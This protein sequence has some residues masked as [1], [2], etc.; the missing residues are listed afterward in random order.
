M[1]PWHESRTSLKGESG[2]FRIDGPLSW[3][4]VLETVAEGSTFSLE[5]TAPRFTLAGGRVHRFPCDVQRVTLYGDGSDQE[6]TVTVRWGRGSGPESVGA[7]RIEARHQYLGRRA[8]VCPAQVS[9]TEPSFTGAPYP[10]WTGPLGF[11][12]AIGPTVDTPRGLVVSAA[13]TQV[14]RDFVLV[15]ADDMGLGGSA[16]PVPLVS[17][18]SSAQRG[19]R[20]VASAC[21]ECLPGK[22]QVYVANPNVATVTVEVAA[23]LVY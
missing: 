23:W 6:Q 2:F 19:G 15:I 18:A 11:P 1:L 20:H 3:F 9:P 12:P 4:E 14:G 17:V 16:D 8:Q 13:A 7:L 22:V 10:G 5:G 21:Y